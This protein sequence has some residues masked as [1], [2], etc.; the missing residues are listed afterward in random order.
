[1]VKTHN[2]KGNFDGHPLHKMQVTVGAIYVVCKPL[3]VAVSMTHHFGIGMDGAIEKLGH[4]NVVTANDAQFVSQILGSWSLHVKSWAEITHDRMLVVRYEDM[5]EKPAEV[6]VKLAKRVGV[7]K[8]RARI[9]RAIR[10]S[11]FRTLFGNGEATGVYR[12]IRHGYAF[13]QQGL[14]QRL[15]HPAHLRAGSARD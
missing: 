14:S 12:E 15:A 11:D 4:D 1:F 2:R 3:D 7:G 5:I 6:F 8:G 9:E 13:L 10:H